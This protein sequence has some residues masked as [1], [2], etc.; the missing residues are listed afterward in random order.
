MF[1]KRYQILIVQSVAL[2]SNDSHLCA[3]LYQIFEGGDGLLQSVG[4]DYVMVCVNGRI[5]IGSEQHPFAT[6]VYAY[7]AFDIHILTPASM[8]PLAYAQ[9]FVGLG[10]SLG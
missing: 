9:I 6:D 2:M 10:S 3:A 4:T 8:Q 7:Y 5:D 1:L